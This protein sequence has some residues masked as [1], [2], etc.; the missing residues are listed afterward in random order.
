MTQAPYSTPCITLRRVVPETN[1]RRQY[2]VSVRRD[3]FGTPVVVCRWGRIGQAGRMRTHVCASIDAAEALAADVVARRR[4]RGYSSGND[5]HQPSR[6]RARR[7]AVGQTRRRAAPAKVKAAAAQLM[8]FDADTLRASWQVG[9]GP[10]QTLFCAPL[11][12]DKVSQIATKASPTTPTSGPASPLVAP[13]MH[14][15]GKPATAHERERMIEA[16]INNPRMQGRLGR[17][18]DFVRT[19]QA[20][21]T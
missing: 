13:L 17:G 12:I 19:T 20:T 6:V 10:G 18:R 2:T 9:R 4:Q 7:P 15:L 3:L 21:R 11:T 1:T 14:L 8:L 5:A 16:L